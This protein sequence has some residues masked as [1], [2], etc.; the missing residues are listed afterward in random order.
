MSSTSRIDTNTLWSKPTWWV[1]LG[2]EDVSVCNIGKFRNDKTQHQR[3]IIRTKKRYGG[4]QLH[5][6]YA[7]F[8]GKPGARIFAN[9][10]DGVFPS[11]EEAMAAMPSFIRLL[12]CGREPSSR[13]LNYDDCTCLPGK[14]V[15]DVLPNK[16]VLGV[17]ELD[18]ELTLQ[19]NV[20]KKIGLIQRRKKL[21]TAFREPLRYTIPDSLA[22]NLVESL[23]AERESELHC[24]FIYIIFG[25]ST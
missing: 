15:L 11:R 10:F 5:S 9:S 13:R 1:K 24:K 2:V 23:K 12:N 7:M 14:T 4:V 18:R 16:T 22:D 8:C 20:A 6:H 21:Q 25:S 17:Q 19:R 3:W